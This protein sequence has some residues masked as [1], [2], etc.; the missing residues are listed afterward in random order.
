MFAMAVGYQGCHIRN[1]ATD[2]GG[3][4]RGRSA[5]SQANSWLLCVSLIHHKLKSCLG[6]GPLEEA[7]CAVMASRDG[8]WKIAS[9]KEAHGF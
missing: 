5:S 4:E 7:H 2:Y 1:R 3:S 9:I 8:R 6:A